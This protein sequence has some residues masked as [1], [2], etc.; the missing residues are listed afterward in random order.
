MIF[1][2]LFGE[3]FHLW[4]FCC[5]T[6]PQSRYNLLWCPVFKAA[7]TNWMK[8]IITL[9]DCTEEQTKLLEAKFPG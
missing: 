8:N 4:P 6:L 2:C 3:F 1:V 7:S 9:S 5:E